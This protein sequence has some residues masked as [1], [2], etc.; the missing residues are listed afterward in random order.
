MLEAAEGE[1][2]PR[3]HLAPS[4][5]PRLLYRSRDGVRESRPDGS[6]RVA[7]LPRDDELRGHES[8]RGRSTR[9]RPSRSCAAPSRAGSSSSTR[10]TSTT[11][12][13]ARSSPDIC[14]RGSSARARSTSSRRRCTAGRCRART[15]RGLSRKH[16]LASIDASL[17]GSGW[18]TSTSTRSTAGIRYADRGDDGGA[19]RRRPRGQGALH[20]REQHGRLAVREGAVGR[21]PTPRSCRCRTTTTSSTAKR[22]GR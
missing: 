9:Q 6:A 10:P 22:S 16:I 4:V 15:A 12:A 19:A 21:A 3:G 1:R 8:G 20:R 11:A 17:G 14:S 2:A 5:T 18:T 13:R 7:D